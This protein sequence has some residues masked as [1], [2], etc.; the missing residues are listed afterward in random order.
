MI[1]T[2]GAG[3]GLAIVS[4]C[5]ANHQGKIESIEPRQDEQGAR[6][7]VELPLLAAL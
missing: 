3:L 6:I 4:E 5:I 2:E 1:D 7:R